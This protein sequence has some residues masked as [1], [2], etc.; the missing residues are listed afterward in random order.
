[1]KNS[2]GSIPW[3]FLLLGV[4][5]LTLPGQDR[6]ITIEG[7]RQKKAL[8]PT[9]NTRKVRP[10][11]D[12][13]VKVIKVEFGDQQPL[14][15]APGEDNLPETP[16]YARKYAA[17]SD[18]RQFKSVSGIRY[19]T[20]EPRSEIKYGTGEPRSEIRYGVTGGARNNIAR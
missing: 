8:S 6:Q 18:S 1:M 15:A 3:V 2:T 16:I 17:R 14:T 7:A 20:G 10:A 11:E 5:A 13:A 19:G 4:T 9:E 12:G